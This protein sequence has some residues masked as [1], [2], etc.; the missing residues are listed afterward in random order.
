MK[1]FL[2]K[3]LNLGNQK[4]FEI[5]VNQNVG[6]IWSI[7]KKFLGSGYEKDDLYQIGCVGFIKAVRR[8][9]LNLG[10][11]LSTF[12]VPY[13]TGEIK[14][15]I[16]DDGIIKISRSIKE[17]GF[18]VRVDS[19]NEEIFENGKEEKLER[20]SN[21]IDEQSKIIERLSLDEAIKNLNY[22]DKKIIIL[23]YFN[24]KTQSE[25]AKALG[26]SQV[27]VSRIERKI[28][29]NIKEKMVG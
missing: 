15:F 12:A 22:R 29:N 10:Y 2:L 4:S 27:Q 9:D 16:R 13:I 19:I 23:R 18:R 28:L 5:L 21:K 1:I 3:R 17:L 26:I 14:K 20:I 24:G 8:F 25:V 7:V 6:L 11:K